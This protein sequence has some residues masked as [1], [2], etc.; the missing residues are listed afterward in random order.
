MN[1]DDPLIPGPDGDGWLTRPVPGQDPM[2]AA[3]EAIADYMNF[4][5]IA[6]PARAADGNLGPPPDEHVLDSLARSEGLV[7]EEETQ[8]RPAAGTVAVVA[9]LPDCDVCGVLPAR[10]D[11]RVLSNEELVAVFACA[12]CYDDYGQGSLG[13][14][15]DVWLMLKSEVSPEVRAV[16]DELSARLGR[17]SLWI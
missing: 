11:G 5:A 1:A 12:A 13:A 3:M 6:W 4:N 10:I 16:C 2:E 7:S 9:A 17:P 14:S 15:G 8:V